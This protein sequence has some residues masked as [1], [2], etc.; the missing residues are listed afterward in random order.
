MTVQL[1]NI[2][3]SV[4]GVKEYNVNMA[5]TLLTGL[6]PLIDLL[7]LRK[8]FRARHRRRRGERVRSIVA[9]ASVSKSV[10]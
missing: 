1:N 5:A 2:V 9:T 4:Q 10:I 3:N 6:V 7:R 8:A